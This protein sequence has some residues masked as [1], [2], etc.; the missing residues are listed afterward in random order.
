VDGEA[1][2]NARHKTWDMLKFIKASSPLPWLCV[3]DFN[4]VLGREE[5]MGVNEWSNAQIQEFRDTDHICEFMDLG[6]TGTT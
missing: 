2:V 5:H 4:E 6:Y 1:Q 3:G